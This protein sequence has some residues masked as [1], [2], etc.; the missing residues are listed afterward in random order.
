MPDRFA[1]A[2][3]SVMARAVAYAAGE[4]SRLRARGFDGK[5]SGPFSDYAGYIAG[6]ARIKAMLAP[7]TYDPILF[8]PPEPT[9]EFERGVPRLRKVERMVR[10]VAPLRDCDRFDIAS[11]MVVHQHLHAAPELFSG[12]VKEKPYSSDVIGCSDAFV[13]GRELFLSGLHDQGLG[14]L[15]VS[16]MRHPFNS[17]YEL[18][19]RI[20]EAKVGEPVNRFYSPPTHQADL[21]LY[22]RTVSD[23][24]NGSK[25]AALDRLERALE[26]DSHNCLANHLLARYFDRPIDERYFFPAPEGM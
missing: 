11:M 2:D 24:Q 5:G 3:L 4:P 21:Y 17:K 19:F 10:Q 15:R 8:D 14:Y 20:A 9:V 26:K 23:L 16:F 18:W 7:A 13:I 25:E 12:L 1:E 22:Y 6:V